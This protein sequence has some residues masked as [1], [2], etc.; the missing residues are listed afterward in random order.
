MPQVE[1]PDQIIAAI[2]GFL[3]VDPLKALDELIRAEHRVRLRSLGEAYRIGLRSLRAEFLTR[4]ID[5]LRQVNQHC[6][7]QSALAAHDV[8]SPIASR[9]AEQSSSW[10]N[11]TLVDPAET[12]S[13]QRQLDNKKENLRLIQ[14]RITE[15]VLTM[16]VPL[17]Y[18]KEEQQC[19]ADI[20][21]LEQQL[22]VEVG[23]YDEP[24]LSEGLAQELLSLIALFRNE[25]LG[26]QLAAVRPIIA[27]LS[28]SEPLDGSQIISAAC[29]LW[30]QFNETVRAWVVR[31]LVWVRA[32]N[33]PS[34]AQ[35][36]EHA[37]RINR[38]LRRLSTDAALHDWPIIQLFAAV[39][40]RW[41]SRIKHA[42]AERPPVI[43][44][45]NDT[46]LKANPFQPGAAQFDPLL[47]VSY[48]A[49]LRAEEISSP[50]PM[51]LVSEE[52]QDRASLRL[53]MGSQHQQIGLPQGL[54]A[55]CE[56]T[57]EFK[58]TPQPVKAY[59]NLIARGAAWSWLEFLPLNAG[60]WFDLSLGQQ[61]ALVDLLVW[62]AQSK[63]RP[64]DQLH[65]NGL[66]EEGESQAL[67]EEMAALLEKAT[68]EAQPNEAELLRWLEVRPPFL[69]HTYA[70]LDCPFR[71][72]REIETALSRI[73]A[74]SD[75][76]LE[77]DVVLKVFAAESPVLMLRDDLDGMPIAWAER[78][79]TQMLDDRIRLTAERGYQVFADLFYPDD[80]AGEAT[81]E[82]IYAASGSLGRL[83]RLGQKII[84]AHVAEGKTAWDVETV[85]KILNDRQ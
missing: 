59:L 16:D 81:T 5:L 15:F 72:G 84:M 53:L 22:G 42:R 73:V 57:D 60:V 24:E 25:P 9:L 47:L 44:F 2:R 45:L 21:Q 23:V 52:P 76:L 33:D 43:K 79:L 30:D 38:Q 51:L 17:Q 28:V 6:R 1:Q 70:L 65:L 62:Y 49:P 83:Q 68:L 27:G 55:V 13:L 3:A 77:A 36:I 74:V 50:R 56:L 85:L 48:A 7:E 32:Q 54:P 39:D 31:A 8:S 35:Q 71:A 41:P 4:K 78:N 46:G 37:F 82:L 75:R 61:R 64:I 20:R 19:I 63:Q 66:A 18:R 10:T 14:E 67:K 69:N 34:L 58:T 40:Y 80:R 26:P 12:Q 11:P 29:W